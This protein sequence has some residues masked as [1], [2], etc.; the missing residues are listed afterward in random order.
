MPNCTKPSNCTDSGG[1][2]ILENTGEASEAS[3]HNGTCGAIDIGQCVV[4]N[5]SRVIVR[6]VP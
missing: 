2:E 5:N 6:E 4:R 1:S 3:D